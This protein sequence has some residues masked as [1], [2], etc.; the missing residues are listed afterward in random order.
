MLVFL[1]RK[2]NFSDLQVQMCFDSYHIK[3]FH[4]L[5]VPSPL[6]KGG[7]FS[8]SGL[9]R[10][11]GLHTYSSNSTKTFLR[12]RVRPSAP[13][14]RFR[15]TASC[16]ARHGAAQRSIPRAPIPRFSQPPRALLRAVLSETRPRKP[17]P[18]S[19]PDS[20]STQSARFRQAYHHCA[21]DVPTSP[22]L[23]STRRRRDAV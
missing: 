5:R 2:S 7:A 9:E 3:E 22:L 20:D 18:T 23:A 15:A 13:A 11:E 17:S 4:L 21:G 16:Q 10:P 1:P 14:V 6:P 12:P 19:V 8:R